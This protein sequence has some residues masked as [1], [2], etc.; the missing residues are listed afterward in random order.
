MSVLKEALPV[1]PVKRLERMGIGSTLLS[2]SSK[3][4]ES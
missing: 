4:P 1:T 3:K 2:S